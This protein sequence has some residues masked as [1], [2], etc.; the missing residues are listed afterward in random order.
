MQN[1]V[2]LKGIQYLINEFGKRTAVVID[3]EEWGEIWE[4][5]YDVMVAELRKDES[6]VSWET[7]KT[8]LNAETDFLNEKI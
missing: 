7:L 3:L 1:I 8:E 2:N 4:D 5:F 6:T